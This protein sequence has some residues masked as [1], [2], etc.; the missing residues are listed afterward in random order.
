MPRRRTVSACVGVALSRT[1]IIPK[2]VAIDKVGERSIKE[3]VMT[4]LAIIL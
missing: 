1:P 3:Y 4:T 2:K